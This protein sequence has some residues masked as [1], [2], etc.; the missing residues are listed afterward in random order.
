MTSD[1]LTAIEARANAATPGLWKVDGYQVWHVGARYQN[2]SDP[3]MLLMM[4][5]CHC[6]RC[7]SDRAFVAAA[8]S[9]VPA[10]VAEV[11]RL[12]DALDYV[13][14]EFPDDSCIVDRTRRIMDGRGK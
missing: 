6:E 4:D 1:E 14:G 9:D 2:E 13:L 12:M 3:H 10:L 11:R 7:E 5:G 8:R